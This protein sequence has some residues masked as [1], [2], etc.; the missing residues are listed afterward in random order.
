[1]K[2]LAQFIASLL[3]LLVL[4]GN[5]DASRRAFSPVKY[6]SFAPRRCSHNYQSW[7]NSK[8]STGLEFLEPDDEIKTCG[9]SR[10]DFVLFV[11]LSSNSSLRR[12]Y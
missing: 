1:M 9:V 11:H 6:P 5:A 10:V 12:I 8:R 7:R 3:L 2:N 4:T